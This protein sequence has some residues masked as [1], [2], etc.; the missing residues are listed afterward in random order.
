VIGQKNRRPFR[1]PSPTE[2]IETKQHDVATGD[3][4]AGGFLE[5]LVRVGRKVE[6]MVKEDDIYTLRWQWQR[7]EITD[8]RYP[9]CRFREKA[10]L[11]DLV[12]VVEETAFWRDSQL[13]EAVSAEPSQMFTTASFLFVDQ[14]AP[15]RR[16]QP[17]RQILPGGDQAR[18]SEALS[19]PINEIQSGTIQ[20]PSYRVV[21]Q[22]PSTR[23]LSAISPLET[24]NTGRTTHREALNAGNAGMSITTVINRFRA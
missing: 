7:I 15:R 10:E 19:Y 24:S 4:D 13:R 6:D 12:E 3:N 22:A 11:V 17:S 20:Q 5:H 16:C 18:N 14:M 1:N 9:G 2:G 21:M 8:R 23:S